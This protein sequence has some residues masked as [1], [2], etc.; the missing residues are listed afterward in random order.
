MAE[1]IGGNAVAV[2]GLDPDAAASAPHDAPHNADVQ[3][4]P[5]H[6]PVLDRLTDGWARAIMDRLGAAWGVR[7]DLSKTATRRERLSSFASRFAEPALIGVLRHAQSGETGLVALDRAAV[8]GLVDLALGGAGKAPTE[9]ALARPCTL[10]ETSLIRSALA[11][12]LETFVACLQPAGGLP[13]VFDRWLTDRDEVVRPREGDGA[14]VL[15]LTFAFGGIDAQIALALPLALVEPIRPALAAAWPGEALGQDLVWREHIAR[16][17]GRS[18]VPLTAVLH[19]AMMPISR[20]K[21]LVEGDTLMFDA[22][23]DPVI[24]IRAGVVRIAAGKLGRSNGHA[25]VRFETSAATVVA[26]S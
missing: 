26:A 1:G 7:P 19:E 5:L 4:L 10:L 17:L 6:L 2:S 9:A 21:S 23:A 12:V 24:D 13:L 18:R 22:V 8:F 20:I 11:H 15:P 14:L 3:A 16:E 25:A